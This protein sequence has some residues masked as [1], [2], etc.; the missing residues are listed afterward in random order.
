MSNPVSN[1]SGR[2][3]LRGEE[4]LAFDLIFEVFTSKQLAKLLT[5]PL[6]R[7][8][9]K[10]ER[11]L[12]QR[13]VG[14]GAGIG[15]ALDEA[16]RRGHREIVSD[17]VGAGA[18]IGDALH[19]AVRGGHGD[20]V[21]DLVESGASLA[22]G[23]D[24]HTPL[25]NAVAWG[26][27]EI[28]KLLVLKGADKDAFDEGNWTPLYLA[29]FHGEPDVVLA[30]LTAGADMSIRCG[31]TKT[32][33]THRAALQGNVEMLRL[34]IEHGADVEAVD[35]DGNTALHYA[36]G[37]NDTEFVD[38]LVE[39]GANLEA[40]DSIGCT[41]LHAAASELK[42]EGV[43]CL[44]KHG[45]KINAQDSS[46]RT[47]LMHSAVKAGK[48]GAAEMVDSLLRAGA[49]ETIV[50]RLG[51]K[52]VDMIGT[53]VGLYQVCLAEDFE[54]VHELLANAPAD[55]AWRRRGYLVLC[56]AHPDRVQQ[57]QV[58]GGTH[59]ADAGRENRNLEEMT[60]VGEVMGG[61]IVD[62]STGGGWVV[63]VS[64]VLRLQEGIFR[65]IVGYL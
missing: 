47:T 35:A 4:V 6:E 10:G 43:V 49:D 41:P 64:R 50:D 9:A 20:I 60:R 54:R 18:G 61:N 14:A 15:N 65:S 26:E 16:I 56:R 21:S 53:D 2:E 19:E 42:H 25:H 45:A 52:A 12:A 29:V 51:L 13:L 63:V 8:V 17:L 39:A 31:P 62:E 33:L 7:A 28:A 5:A 3:A 58:I 44:L 57:G 32:S 34:V 22:K 37:S 23:A 40:R 1:K 38:V 27:T 24:G 48:P 11:D 46:L 59:H 30:L 36:G 55:R